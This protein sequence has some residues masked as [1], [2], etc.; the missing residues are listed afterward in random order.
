MPG[1][2]EDDDDIASLDRGEHLRQIAGMK[3]R[4]GLDR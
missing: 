1:R 3:T 4:R 2:F